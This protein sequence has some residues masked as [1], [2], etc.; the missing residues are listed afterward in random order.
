MEV[1]EIVNA[2]PLG[3]DA[4]LKHAFNSGFETFIAYMKAWSTVASTG[5]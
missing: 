1:L 5:A 4:D 2:S 3:L